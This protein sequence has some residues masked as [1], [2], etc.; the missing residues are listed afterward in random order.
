MSIRHLP[1][2]LINATAALLVVTFVASPTSAQDSGWSVA[3]VQGSH[4]DITNNG[5]LVARYMT[6]FDDST[7]ERFHETYKPYLHIFD[8]DGK[9]PITKG[10]GG[11]FTHHRGIFIG[12]SRVQAGGAS[13]DLW[14]MKGVYQK[15]E[16]FAK[17]ESTGD[18]ATLVSS[19]TWVDKEGKPL[20]REERSMKFLDA[21]KPAL[22]RVDFETKLTA[23]RSLKL[24]GDPEHAGVQYRP[25][26]EIVA[27]ET[28]YRFPKE[29]ADPKKDKDYPWVGEAYTVEGKRYGVVHMNHP[30][31]PRGTVYSAYR[32]YGRFGAFFKKELE[33]GESLTLKYG[34]LIR[35]G[36]LPET[37]EIRSTWSEFAGQSA[38]AL[39]PPPPGAAREPK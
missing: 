13:F 14:H 11:R 2:R 7:P 3:V 34:F 15:H 30:T 10:A 5:R 38:R 24:N 12:W 29:N 4:A 6:A 31:N 1:S 39:A 8:A 28:I 9:K 17:S 36:G 21:D 32:D 27:S 16:G 25:A 33:A 26:N 37:E 22:V 20:I 35:A 18:G 23:V 19:V